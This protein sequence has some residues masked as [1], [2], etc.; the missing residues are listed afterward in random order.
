MSVEPVGQGVLATIMKQMSSPGGPLS[1]LLSWWRYSPGGD[2]QLAVN[3]QLVAMLS[4][5]RCS[6]G[7]HTN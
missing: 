6:V 2:A 7:T 4:W 1:W 5:L 3:A